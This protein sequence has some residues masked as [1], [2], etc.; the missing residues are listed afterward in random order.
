[1]VVVED[2]G[3]GLPPEQATATAPPVDPWATSGRGLN[4]IRELMT[5][6]AVETA[7]RRRGTRVEMRKVLRARSN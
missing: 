2:E 1:V 7:P 4:I 6:V 3:I 5:S